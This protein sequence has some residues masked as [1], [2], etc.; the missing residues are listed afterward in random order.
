MYPK[1]QEDHGCGNSRGS[2]CIYV[3]PAIER[4]C[5]CKNQLTG[6]GRYMISRKYLTTTVMLSIMVLLSGLTACGVQKNTDETTSVAEDTSIAE[7]QS[8][9]TLTVESET[10]VT[11]KITTR[12]ASTSRCRKH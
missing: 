1:E 11:A 10:A 9:E 6:G 8:R 4:T 7:E 12:D 2:F 3:E 5:I